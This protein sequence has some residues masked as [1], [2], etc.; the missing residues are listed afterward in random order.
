MRDEAIKGGEQALLI[1]R[2]FVEIGG[3]LMLM[4]DGK[5]D[6]QLDLWSIFGDVDPTSA[7]RGF[8]IGRRF[9]RR[10]HNPRFARSVAALVATEGERTDN[11]WLVM[12]ARS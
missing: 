8:V 4:P 6:T 5:L 11:G 7:R 2:A 12:E 10:L 1:A 9:A 3:R